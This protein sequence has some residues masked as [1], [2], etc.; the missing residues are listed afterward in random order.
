MKQY[1]KIW[2]Q[3]PS[4]RTSERK[5]QQLLT[6][7][8]ETSDKSVGSCLRCLFSKIRPDFRQIEFGAIS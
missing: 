5:E 6:S 2:C 7:L 1:T 3:L 4:F 8:V